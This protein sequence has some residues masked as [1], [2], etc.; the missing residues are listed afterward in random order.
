MHSYD[1]SHIECGAD[2]RPGFQDG[3][4]KMAQG[5]TALEGD[6]TFGKAGETGV[7]QGLPSV[8]MTPSGPL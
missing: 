6:Q 1:P 8:F 3:C 4:K 2:Q 7:Q 5:M